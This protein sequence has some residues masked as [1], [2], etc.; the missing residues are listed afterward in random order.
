MPKMK[1]KSST[2]RRFRKTGSGKTIMN[3]AGKRH[4]L[5]KRS[6]KMKR[7]ARGTQV[8]TASDARIVA[9]FMPYA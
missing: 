3:F 7:S 8:M 5:N 2:K 6:Q 4:N 1:T 9:K